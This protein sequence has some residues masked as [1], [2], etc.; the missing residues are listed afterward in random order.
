VIAAS[1]PGAPIGRAPGLMTATQP[2][3]RAFVD[4]SNI[5]LGIGTATR[6]RD[7]PGLPV[8]LSAD[9][10]GRVL[11]AGRANFAQTTVANADVPASV[12]RHYREFGTVIEREPGRTSGTEQANDETLQVRIYE[13]LFAYPA[14][15]LVLATGDGAGWRDRR[16]FLAVLEAARGKKWAV[17]IV[18][19]GTSTN[20]ALIDWARKVRAPVIDLDDFY[21]SVTF[22]HGGRAAQG[23]S[24]RSRPTA[25]LAA[26]STR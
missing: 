15:I 19:W 10:L 20:G 9:H 3:V 14:G 6:R 1:P 18:A 4:L 22:V 12:L 23:V 13:T 24:L 8:R 11:R 5:Y 17:E 26:R 25:E 21:Y 7:E 16:G 2:A